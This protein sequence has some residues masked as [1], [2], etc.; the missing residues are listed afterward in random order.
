MD[1]PGSSISAA[2]QQAPAPRASIQDILTFNYPRPADAVPR[3][4]APP[5]GTVGAQLASADGQPHPPAHES[6]YTNE[7]SAQSP[8]ESSPRR[9]NINSSKRAA[10]NRAAQRAFR[11]RRERYVAG[12]EEKARNYDRL[13]AALLDAQ[14]ENYHLRARLA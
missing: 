9:R 7:G 1:H 10:Q 8:A 12:L 3:P 14:R 13:E 6:E 5:A 2:P 4:P 11:L